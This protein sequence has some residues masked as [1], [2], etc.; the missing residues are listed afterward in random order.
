MNYLCSRFR[1]CFK[2]IEKGNKAPGL[3][4]FRGCLKKNGLK[5]TPQRLAVHA[6][7]LHLG[8]AC[9]DQVAEHI[10]KENKTKVTVAS[11]YNILTQLSALGI[12]RHRMSANNKMYFDVNTFK[13]LHLYDTVNNEYRDV[14]DDDLIRDIEERL[15]KRRFKG[16]RVDGIDIQILCRPTSRRRNGPVL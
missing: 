11:V 14:L 7:M 6:A 13:H 15:G 2:M 10:L 1:S 3:E 12:Y 8:H 5:V 4:E 16:Y 9:A